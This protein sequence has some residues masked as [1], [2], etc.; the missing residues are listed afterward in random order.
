ME[1]RYNACDVYAA[2]QALSYLEVVDNAI[3]EA[4]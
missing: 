2:N 3:F 4:Y 1:V